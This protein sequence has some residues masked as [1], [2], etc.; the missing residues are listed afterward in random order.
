MLSHQTPRVSIGESLN[1]S[2]KEEKDVED[3]VKA[4]GSRDPQE[5]KRE[6]YE[7]TTTLQL[8]SL[9]Q[10]WPCNKPSS[11]LTECLILKFRRGGSNLWGL[12]NCQLY[13]TDGVLLG[14]KL[15][16]YLLNWVR[17][18][19]RYA[20][21]TVPMTLP[22]THLLPHIWKPDP[23]GLCFLSATQVIGQGSQQ[24]WGSNPLLVCRIPSATTTSTVPLVMIP[25]YKD[26]L[27]SGSTAPIEL[28]R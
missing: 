23:D 3:A 10:D 21:S 18:P 8:P 11:E 4:I 6:W 13:I 1:A 14:R 15:P 7:C 12:T 17:S 22:V 28:H 20:G 5:I 24:K 2:A 26:T 19:L 9:H 27:S 16:P 25:P